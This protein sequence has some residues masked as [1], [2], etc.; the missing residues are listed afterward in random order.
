MNVIKLK[1]YY[2]KKNI[3]IYLINYKIILYIIMEYNNNK[4]KVY[5]MFVP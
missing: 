1:Y 3:K 4:K 5:T 2:R